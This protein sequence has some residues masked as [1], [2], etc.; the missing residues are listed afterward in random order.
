MGSSGSSSVLIWTAL[1]EVPVGRKALRDEP[2][3]ARLSCGRQQRVGALG[4]QLVRL[5]KGLV[6][7]TAELRLRERR[8]LVNDRIRLALEHGLAHCVR[9]K[10]VNPDRLRAER[11][12]Q[13]GTRR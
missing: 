7:A 12:Q 3:Y 2:A 10:Q 13:F 8:G 6:E 1:P 9:V 5:G 4:P 11:S